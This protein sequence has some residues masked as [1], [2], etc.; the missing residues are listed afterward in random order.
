M[1]TPCAVLAGR[2]ASITALANHLANLTTLPAIGFW[3]YPILCSGDSHPFITFHT[4]G[5]ENSL[6]A[7]IRITYL[8]DS[9]LILRVCHHTQSHLRWIRLRGLYNG[10]W[11]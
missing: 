8:L 11:N 5:H 6:K 2:T 9:I 10:R 3:R 7:K 4:F 1:Y